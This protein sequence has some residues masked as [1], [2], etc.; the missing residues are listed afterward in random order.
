VPSVPDETDAN[1]RK[2]ALREDR[3]AFRALVVAHQHAVHAVLAQLLFRGA[4]ADVDDLAQET[5]LRVHRALPR[6]EDHGPGRLK[7]WIVTIAARV[8]IDHLRRKRLP[9]ESFDETVHRLPS[10]EADEL[11]QFRRLGQRVEAALAELG[12]EQRS[13]LVLRQLHG[14]EYQEIADAL[15]IDLGTVRSRLH[16]ARA[17]LELL[18][19]KERVG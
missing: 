8:A 16:R 11:A 18:L 10:R 15:Q 1:A 9:L 3:A 12:A 17:K 19:I 5:F 14:L 7:K 13:V 4:V 2:C 6:F